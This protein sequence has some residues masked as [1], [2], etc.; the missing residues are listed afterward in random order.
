MFFMSILDF[1]DECDARE[2]RKYA[3]QH[4]IS[5]GMLAYLDRL[6]AKKAEEK[7]KQ[8]QPQTL[9]EWVSMNST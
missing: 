5:E 1:R 4:G 2:A 3:D 9:E 8:H 7:A 6:D